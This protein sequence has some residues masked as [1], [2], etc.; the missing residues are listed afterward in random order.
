M[1]FFVVK[2]RRKAE[3]L[4][5]YVVFF[6]SRNLKINQCLPERRDDEQS[7]QVRLKLC[8]D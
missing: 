6:S 2:E 5:Y 8:N 3:N 4:H 1:I 7:L